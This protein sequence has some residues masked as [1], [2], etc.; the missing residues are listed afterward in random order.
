MGIS[1]NLFTLG[2]LIGIKSM[3]QEYI[4]VTD[5]KSSQFGSARAI[6]LFI[7]SIQ[8]L[9]NAS[10]DKS[11][12]TKANNLAASVDHLRT[13][14]FGSSILETYTLELY[15]RKIVLKEPRKAIDIISKKGYTPVTDLT[16]C[17]L[18]YTLKRQSSAS[19]KFSKY[20]ETLLQYDNLFSVV[21]IQ[22]ML[23]EL[24][25][26]PIKEVFAEVI[27]PSLRSDYQLSIIQGLGCKIPVVAKLYNLLETNKN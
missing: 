13:C 14:F 25:T 1:E 15:L 18:Q 12:F 5:K 27:S 19:K 16:K 20:V 22:K 3:I 10:R 7:D 26:E 8:S 17:M 4:Q 6:Y 23:L 11:E 9:Q 2:D 21:T 24:S